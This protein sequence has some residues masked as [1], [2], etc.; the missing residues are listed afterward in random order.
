MEEQKPE[1]QKQTHNP[2][3][4]DKTWDIPHSAPMLL[5][6]RSSQPDNLFP[7]G[8]EMLPARPRAEVSIYLFCNHVGNP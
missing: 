5:F 7:Q 6:T 2:N 3:F 8:K 1:K 4:M